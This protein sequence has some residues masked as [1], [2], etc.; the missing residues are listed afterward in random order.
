MLGPG[1]VG[2]HAVWLTDDD[3]AMMADAGAAV[4][5]NPGEQPPAGQ[6]H[7]AMREMLDRG[8]TVGLGTDGSVVPT[9]RTSSRPCASPR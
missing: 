3:I 4:A 5:H 6:R 2:A 9:T 8:V 7:R 1:F